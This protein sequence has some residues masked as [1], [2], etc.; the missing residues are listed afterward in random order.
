[1]RRFV[2]LVALNHKVVVRGKL[3]GRLGV[4]GQRAG[5]YWF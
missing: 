5:S 2:K 3:S 1:M 4:E